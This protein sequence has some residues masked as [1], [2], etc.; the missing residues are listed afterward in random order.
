MPSFQDRN[1]HSSP[2]GLGIPLGVIRAV[3]R[4]HCVPAGGTTAP[5]ILVGI[6]IRGRVSVGCTRECIF[7][8]EIP[9]EELESQTV[10]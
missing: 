9:K 7:R 4:A 5:Q 1:S 6:D 2:F 3:P 10:R 8:Y